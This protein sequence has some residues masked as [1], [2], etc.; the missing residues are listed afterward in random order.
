ME[1]MRARGVY[2][3]NCP[4]SNMN[5]SSGIA[6]VRKFLD[7]GIPVGLGSDVAGGC[8]PSIFRA[9]TDAIQASKMHWRLV[10]E[11]DAPL[12][13]AEA[14]YLATVG[15]G[16]F[17][18]KVGSFAEGYELDAVVIDDASIATVEPLAIE[19]RLARVAYLSEDRNIKQ[20]VVRGQAILPQQPEKGGDRGS[21]SLCYPP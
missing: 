19:D 3:A 5:L 7:K 20:K 12:T 10:D 8:H 21:R 2:M 4:Q 16:S 11:Q 13:L 18:G 9:M 15:G 17:F 6:P 14:F 1:L